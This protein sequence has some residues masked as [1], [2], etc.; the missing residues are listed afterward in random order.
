MWDKQNLFSQKSNKGVINIIQCDK[1]NCCLNYFSVEE[2]LENK[3]LLA[4]SEFK[5]Q[6]K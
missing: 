1:I 3:N 4:Y 5:T 6:S 2:K